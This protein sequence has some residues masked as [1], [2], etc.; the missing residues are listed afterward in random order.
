MTEPPR[1]AGYAGTGMVDAF[2]AAL[3]ASDGKHSW[4]WRS[5]GLNGAPVVFQ[6]P[7][8]GVRGKAS[9]ERWLSVSALEPSERGI[10]GLADGDPDWVLSAQPNGGVFSPAMRQT[11]ASQAL[12]LD[13]YAAAPTR[14]G[15][16][17]SRTWLVELCNLMAMLRSSR[18]GF[19]LVAGGRE[20]APFTEMMNALGL[21][22][23][24]H[25]VRLWS[26]PVL[27]IEPFSAETIGEWGDL[28]WLTVRERRQR[29]VR[30]LLTL[31]D[32][33]CENNREHD[34]MRGAW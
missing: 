24:A 10:C 26:V 18:L 7:A 22:R 30:R 15:R 17:R 16:Q 34:E 5:G 3:C 28:G 29:R 6:C 19:A 32:K 21:L 33:Y 2:T 9:L 20:A 25:G 23:A 11:A 27:E 8:C 14:V 1:G 4:Y 12:L 31:W 13:H